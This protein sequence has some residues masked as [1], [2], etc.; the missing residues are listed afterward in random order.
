MNET[1]KKIQ[2]IGLRYVND[3]KIKGFSKN[4]N[5]Y[6]DTD[7]KPIKDKNTLERLSK[8]KIP[9]AWKKVWI[10]PFTNS[11]LQV[12]GIDEKGRKQ[13][14]YHEE[15]S[16][17]MQ[18][19]KFSKLAF[20]GEILPKIRQTIE[21]DMYEKSLSKKRVVPT[22]VWIIENTFIRVGNSEYVKKNNSYGLT[23]LRNKHVK[24]EEGKAIFK[25]TGKSGV[26]HEIDIYH[27]RVVKTIRKCV[28]LPGYELFQYID[29]DGKRAVID[30]SDV[31][32]YLKEITGEDVTAKD[33]RTW[34][35]TLLT[36]ETLMTL[37]HVNSKKD[38]DKNI[39]QAIKISSKYLHNKP[40]TCRKYY[41]HPKILDAYKEGE[42]KGYFI[43]AEKIEKP[44]LTKNE[45][46]VLELLKT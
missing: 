10:S 6:F 25:F 33:F 13:Y 18:E 11:H 29:E 36:A 14:L 22:L 30:S 23:T 20:F 4:N 35:A 37:N 15:W 31:N 17:I 38:A 1:V 16:R 41:I 9:P 28:E 8:L 45:E 26:E 27:P 24:I 32:N 40:A 19:N 3:K 43:K 44:K 42:L 21:K 39:T 46:A 12:T 2:K 7:G 5:S 34:G